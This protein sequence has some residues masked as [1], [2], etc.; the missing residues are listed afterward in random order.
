MTLETLAPLTLDRFGGLVT[1]LD[2]ADLP[3]GTASEAT[4]IEFFP[5]SFRSRLGFAAYVNGPATTGLEDIL[6]VVP[7][8]ATTIRYALVSP[9]TGGA[10][11]WQTF[12]TGSA[13]TDL[14]TAWEP[15]MRAR[16]T[17]HGRIGFAAMT[18]Q[19]TGI[20]L[21]CPVKLFTKEPGGSSYVGRI[22]YGPPGTSSTAAVSAAGL[23]TAGVHYGVVVYETLSGYRSAPTC[24]PF[25]F[26]I[27]G[28]NN[29][30][31]ISNIP[32][33]KITDVAKRLI[34]LT[35]ANP[36]LGGASYPL[37]GYYCVEEASSGMVIINNLATQTT[38]SV[39]DTALLAGTS[40]D[41]LRFLVPLPPSA[42]L[43]TY[44]DRLVAWGV[45]N[46]LVPIG[47][48]QA[49]T[50]GTPRGGAGFNNLR[51]DSFQR[52]T[53]PYTPAFAVP[54][55]LPTDWAETSGGSAAGCFVG[56]MNI[57]GCDDRGMPGLAWVMA[58]AGAGTVGDI[59]HTMDGYYA[60]E[61]LRG[62]RIRFAARREGAVAAG[63]LVVTLINGDTI[64]LTASTIPTNGWKMY[65]YELAPAGT[66]L[67]VGSFLSVK[68]TAALTN[69]TQIGI[70]DIIIYQ[71][72]EQIF[73]NDVFLSR[74]G[75]P[76]AF[77]AF[78]GF[79]GISAG[80]GQ[81]IRCCFP[82][83]SALYMV[84]ETSL[85]ETVDTGY[86]EP[87]TWSVRPVSD[88]VGTH[89]AAG[90]AVG[91]GWAVIVGVNGVYLF[92]G[93][94]PQKISHEIDPTLAR[95]DWAAY[96]HLAWV[97]L[98][99]V[100]KRVLIGLPVDGNTYCNLTL[101][102]D[103]NEGW[104]DPIANEGV[105]RK[106]A[107]WGLSG[108]PST[109]TRPGMDWCV[110]DPTD[111]KLILN[112]ASLST[113]LMVKYPSAG[114]YSDYKVA[115]AARVV[116]SYTTGPLPPGTNE[117]KLFGYLIVAASGAGALA[118]SLVKMNNAVVTLNAKTLAASPLHDIEWYLNL[119]AERI[120]LRFSSSASAVTNHIGVNRIALYQRRS[121]YTP[122][123]G[124]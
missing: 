61:P 106:W 29:T 99:A 88:T 45:R 16:V 54:T 90:V 35:P 104:G 115:G 64:T 56:G 13:F 57:T 66:N 38:I 120:A 74:A 30:V 60:L 111:E 59:T 94:I 122:V 100:R 26:T 23:M 112:D 37:S 110:V 63:N 96:G 43:C 50:A 108:T 11:R 109:P 21:H 47:L 95:V 93:G 32:N 20:A 102:V 85:Y 36:P 5:G 65:D 33:A 19:S 75:E 68:C 121:P 34:F 71:A 52:P 78:E 101:V 27:G 89:S 4:N 86:G 6:F 41:D 58:G 18:S 73:A 81:T 8:D 51:F 107:I 39:T 44:N 53:A 82:L 116:P 14:Q 114:V 10:T 40:V 123:R 72:D 97:T 24:V 2:L 55:F 84:R 70:R 17:A 48:D 80:D 76:E 22:G 83:R 92:D 31:V 7:G 3:A 67:V 117:Q 98:D 25:S 28:G 103:Y 119:T 118:A 77:D 91:D 79:A 49:N 105:G 1:L 69:T 46:E 15:G 42:G 87:S 9:S 124:G 12:T 113:V 62:Y